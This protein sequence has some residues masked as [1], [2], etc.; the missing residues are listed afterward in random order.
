MSRLGLI[1]LAAAMLAACASPQ[2]VALE[3]G[4][5]E[6]NVIAVATLATNDCEAQTAST[7]TAAIMSVKVAADRV[8]KGTL[9]VAQAEKIKALGTDAKAWLD[10]ACPSGRLDADALASAQADVKAM[11]DILWSAP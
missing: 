8:R 4:P 11:Q 10:G 6:R 1:A 3:A 5:A 2:P 7:Y 9:P